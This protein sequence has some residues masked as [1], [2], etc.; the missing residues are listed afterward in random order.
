MAVRRKTPP[1]RIARSLAGTGTASIGL[2]PR[3]RLA[4]H[5]RLAPDPLKSRAELLPRHDGVDLDQRVLVGVEARVTVRKIEKTHLRH[6]CIP[7]AGSLSHHTEVRG[8]GNLQRCPE[9]FSQANGCGSQIGSGR[10]SA[11]RN[12]RWR[13]FCLDIFKEKYGVKYEKGA[14]CLTKDKD[15]ILAFLDFPAEHWGHLRTS[16]PIES[17]RAFN[18]TNGVHALDCDSSAP[19]QCAPRRRCRKKLQN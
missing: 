14:A 1:S 12:P 6:R 18:R 7:N 17:P 4:I 2:A 13:Q 3:A 8:W 11:R 15:A 5:I 19:K 10:H 16:N 9:L